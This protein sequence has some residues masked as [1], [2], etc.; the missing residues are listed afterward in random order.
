MKQTGNDVGSS[1]ADHGDVS[2]IESPL[3]DD[4]NLH[5]REGEMLTENQQDHELGKDCYTL[6]VIGCHETKAIPDE[7]P[8]LSN[9]AHLVQDACSVMVAESQETSLSMPDLTPFVTSDKHPCEDSTSV[10]AAESQETSVNVLDVS[11]SMN[12]EAHPGEDTCT[13]IIAESEE[14]RQSVP[15]TLSSVPDNVLPDEYSKPVMVTESEETRQS[16]P[17][18]PPSMHSGTDKDS[19]SAAITES[20]EIMPKLPPT[21]RSG[22]TGSHQ[23]VDSIPAIT[24]SQEIKPDAQPSFTCDEL[25]GETNSV[26]VAENQETRPAGNYAPPSLIN[27]THDSKDC[28]T[29]VVADSQESKPLIPSAPPVI[30][31]DIHPQMS[32]GSFH[33][34]NDEPCTSPTQGGNSSAKLEAMTQGIFQPPKVQTGQLQNSTEHRQEQDVEHLQKSKAQTSEQD[35]EFPVPQSVVMDDLRAVP[36]HTNQVTT[37]CALEEQFLQSAVEQLQTFEEK[38]ERDIEGT[39]KVPSTDGDTFQT[40]QMTSPGQGAEDTTLLLVGVDDSDAVTVDSPITQNVFPGGVESH[41]GIGESPTPEQDN[42]LS[43]HSTPCDVSVDVVGV[44]TNQNSNPGSPDETSVEDENRQSQNSEHPTCE[45]TDELVLQI[46]NVNSNALSKEAE[47]S[48]LL[49]NPKRPTDTGRALVRKLEDVQPTQAS[50]DSDGKTGKAVQEPRRNIFEVLFQKKAIIPDPVPMSALKVSAPSPVL[51]ASP[52]AVEHTTEKAGPSE[53]SA[54]DSVEMGVTK[55][56]LRYTCDI[57]NKSF[58]KKFQLRGHKGKHGKEGIGPYRSQQDD[59]GVEV[60]EDKPVG[61]VISETNKIDKDASTNSLPKEDSTEGGTSAQRKGDRPLHS[62]DCVDSEGEVVDVSHQTSQPTNLSLPQ[63]TE[64]PGQKPVHPNLSDSATLVLTGETR[65]VREKTS[66]AGASGSDGSQLQDRAFNLRSTARYSLVDMHCEAQQVDQSQMTRTSF[67]SSGK[68]KGK[69]QFSCPHCEKTYAHVNQLNA[70]KRVHMASSKSHS[71][72]K[73]SSD[74]AM[75]RN[76]RKVYRCSIC[77]ATFYSY[78]KLCGHKGAH[79]AHKMTK[80]RKYSNSG[81]QEPNG[82]EFLESKPKVLEPKGTSSVL[83]E[84][85]AKNS[86]KFTCKF[87]PETF[88]YVAQLRN[89]ILVGHPMAKGKL[90]LLKP[91]TCELCGKAFTK[92]KQRLHHMKLHGRRR[93]RRVKKTMSLQD[94]DHSYYKKLPAKHGNVLAEVTG[95]ETLKKEATVNVN[96]AQDPSI[97]DVKTS[98]EKTFSCQLCEKSFKCQQQL[99]GHMNIHKR[100]P[101]KLCTA[102]FTLARQ[103][104]GHLKVHGGLRKRP[105]EENQSLNVQNQSGTSHDSSSRPSTPVQ[106][107]TASRR[108]TRHTTNS[109][110]NALLKRV[111]KIFLTGK[112]KRKKHQPAQTGKW[113]QPKRS[114]QRAL[115]K[116]K[117]VRIQNIIGILRKSIILEIDANS[118]RL[119][120]ECKECQRLS[121]CH[122]TILSHYLETHLQSAEGIE[123]VPAS[124]ISGREDTEP[125]LHQRFR[126]KSKIGCPICKGSSGFQCH[127]HNEEDFI[128]IDA[129][130]GQDEDPEVVAFENRRESSPSRSK[131]VQPCQDNTKRQP[132]DPFSCSHCPFKAKSM[133]S[134]MVHQQFHSE[135]KGDVLPQG[136]PS[137]DSSEGEKLLS[138]PLCSFKVKNVFGLAAHSRVHKGKGKKRALEDE[139]QNPASSSSSSPSPSPK[140]SSESIQTSGDYVKQRKNAYN[141]LFC[142]KYFHT[143]IS[144]RNHMKTHEHVFQFKCSG[145]SQSFLTARMLEDHIKSTHSVKLPYH[146]SKC[147]FSSASYQS[148]LSHIRSHSTVVVNRQRKADWSDYLNDVLKTRVPEA[149]NKVLKQNASWPAFSKEHWSAYLNAVLQTRGPE[150]SSASPNG[151]PTKDALQSLT[152]AGQGR[153]AQLPD[154]GGSSSSA[155]RQKPHQEKSQTTLNLKPK[156]PGMRA[157]EAKSV[158]GSETP[159]IQDRQVKDGPQL[160]SDPPDEYFACSQCKDFQASTKEDWDSHINTVHK[161]GLGPKKLRCVMCQYTTTSQER[162]EQHMRLH[163]HQTLQCNSCKYRTPQ[164]HL[165]IRHVQTVHRQHRPFKCKLCTYATAYR[166]H[167]RRH[168]EKHK[169][170]NFKCRY[171]KLLKKGDWHSAEVSSRV[172]CSE[173]GRELQNKKT[174]RNHYI[175]VHGRIPGGKSL[176]GIPRSTQDEEDSGDMSIGTR[177]LPSYSVICEDVRQAP[178]EKLYECSVCSLEFRRR[179][180]LNQHMAQGHAETQASRPC[181]CP[182]CGLVTGSG[183]LQAHMLIHQEENLLQCEEES[184]S[185]KTAEAVH[186]QRHQAKH[187]AERDVS[188]TCRLCQVKFSDADSLQMHNLQVHSEQISSISAR[189]PFMCSLCPFVSPNEKDANRHFRL[190]NYNLAFKCEYCVFST[191]TASAIATHQKIHRYPRRNIAATLLS[192]K[193]SQQRQKMLAS[194]SAKSADSH[195]S[196]VTGTS[197]ERPRPK[198]VFVSNKGKKLYECRYCQRFFDVAE[199]WQRH[200]LRHMAEW[201]QY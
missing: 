1:V 18:V 78:K 66:S 151:S 201:P 12:S 10:L 146:C 137:R 195:S 36:E 179:S 109:Q 190:H 174:L 133:Q 28:N 168:A 197:P 48:P 191:S 113:L 45:E 83:V 121:Y 61:S 181:Q 44:T 55:N 3:D 111:I 33:R 59:S 186:L 164:R 94:T 123:K 102:S 147:S 155:Y 100:Y 74:N 159:I 9:E 189:A 126:N 58:S 139:A 136:A 47:S 82:Q 112:S 85:S 188:I 43:A 35:N 53:S 108:V 103:L 194:T 15:D 130:L 170:P 156:D 42:K 125:D 60:C 77:H 152:L 192:K 114:L 57:C 76:V 86:G 98:P 141:C 173:C 140:V 119:V 84:G 196:L 96:S 5:I 22:S 19:N 4:G 38:Q 50:G 142:P 117:L 37:C 16:T 198:H 17:S 200:E 71:Y 64:V 118:H 70:H 93:R 7:L 88:Q 127:L 116:H 167:L 27:G 143:V 13:M 65:E 34:H 138:C 87:C 135:R 105:F 163:R 2:A 24:E 145:C 134:L 75:K 6:M 154:Q 132:G 177:K 69:K 14:T 104:C 11:S 29:V 72:V 90:F 131:L 157:A 166:H 172:I 128:A 193:A 183:Q 80:F 54:E 81:S 79:V 144:Y 107:S 8:S 115:M 162:L 25:P 106:L 52:A 180:E 169:N 187:A 31:S 124:A 171:R 160:L 129:L 97:P 41:F 56:T 39:F 49:E 95:T 199:A 153:E 67:K 161:G 176:A 20:L 91:F 68:D 120:Y 101:C 99:A 182:Q 178:L 165:M 148:A 40:S 30:S 46:V 23:I 184:C 73:G 21:P 150:G 26:M 122:K 51:D 89:H 149:P 110:S 158:V 92:S 185:F 175:K 62:T 63:L 32:L